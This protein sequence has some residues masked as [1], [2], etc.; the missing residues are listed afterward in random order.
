MALR[1]EHRIDHR[2][3]VLDRKNGVDRFIIATSSCRSMLF[4]IF[5]PTSAG[6]LECRDQLGLDRTCCVGMDMMNC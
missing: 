6:K 5:P 3:E 4:P 1:H 2:R